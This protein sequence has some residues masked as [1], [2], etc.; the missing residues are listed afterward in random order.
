MK[1]A[2]S[3]LSSPGWTMERTVQAVKEYG[4][5][6]LELRLLDGEV[7][8]PD[9][10]KAS[11]EKIARLCKE[12]GVSVICLDTSVTIAQPDPEKRAAQVR[13]GLAMLEMAAQFSAPLIRVFPG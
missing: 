8:K 6:G 9:L 10:D 5:D 12:A 3:N 7:I 1:I 13:D 11:R 2:Y 4:Y